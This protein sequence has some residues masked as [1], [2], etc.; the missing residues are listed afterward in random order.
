MSTSVVTC[1]SCNSKICYC[2]VLQYNIFWKSWQN[3]D[4]WNDWKVADSRLF[5]KIAPAEP[6]NFT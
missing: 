2:Q 5:H 1:D 6:P 4:F 3:D